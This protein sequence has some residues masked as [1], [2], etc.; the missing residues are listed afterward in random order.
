MPLSGHEITEVSSAGG[1][2]RGE[3]YA[4]GR[5]LGTYSGGTGGTTYFTFSDW[6]GTERAR[7]TSTGVAYE[8]CTSLPFGGERDVLFS[9]GNT[10]KFTAKERDSESG[11]DDFGA[12]YFSSQYGRF[13]SPDPDS[14]GA[15]D[16]NPQTWNGYSYVINNPVRYIDPQGLDHCDDADGSDPDSCTSNGGTWVLGNEP[17]QNAPQQSSPSQDLSWWDLPGQWFVGFGDLVFND[18]PAGAARMGYAYAADL[19]GAAILSGATSLFGRL[20]NPAVEGVCDLSPEAGVLRLKP[21]NHP[22]WRT[23]AI[24]MDHVLSGH[25][26]T[27]ARAM[28]S[29]A[30][31]L[32]PETMP[33]GEIQSA[34]RQAYRY[35]EKIGSQGDTVI[36]QGQSNGLTIQMYVNTVT[37]R[38]ESA[39]PV[40]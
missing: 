40:W 28:Q 32:F 19:G 39:F 37:K 3:V 13:M 8:T 33:E 7:S 20:L 30:K 29:G 14:A 11:L 36:V 35:G 12:R 31:S 21:V 5:H 4:G 1:W 23:I 27:G 38:I 34:I 24:D 17:Q 18:N 22:S 25:T 2:N 9:S 6:L 10:Y 26:A 16:K 15:D